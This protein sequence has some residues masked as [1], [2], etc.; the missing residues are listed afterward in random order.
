MRSRFFGASSYDDDE[1]DEEDMDLSGF[2]TS[3]ETQ[4]VVVERKRATTVKPSQSDQMFGRSGATNPSNMGNAGPKTT[5]PPPMS[6]MGR[7]YTPT[8]EETP[9]GS[10]N[11]GTHLKPL[12]AS[13][14]SSDATAKAAVLMKTGGLSL[15]GLGVITNLATSYK[16]IGA[17]MGIVGVASY[18]HPVLGIRHGML[19]ELA[20]NKSPTFTTIAAL[21]T[22]VAGAG[23]FAKGL[24]KV[25]DGKFPSVGQWRTIAGAGVVGVGGLALIR[26]FR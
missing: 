18:V 3:S 13:D 23:V 19:A 4:P 14:M 6:N 26:K 2:V 7:M 11:W 24:T 20:G 22:N 1:N 16:K 10:I 9:G 21:S 25:S 8:Y 15:V 17:T 5:P 12:Y